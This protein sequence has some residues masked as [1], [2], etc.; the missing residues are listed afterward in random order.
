MKSAF[1]RGFTLIEMLVVVLIIG[2]LAA[3]ALPR[4]QR[5]VLESRYSKSK[6]LASAYIKAGKLYYMQRGSW[7]TLFNSLT[8]TPPKGLKRLTPYGSSDCGSSGDTYCC[9]TTGV[10]GGGGQS[11]G[12]VCGTTDYAIAL[13]YEFYGTQ[14]EIYS[15]VAKNDNETALE[16]CGEEGSFFSNSN[17]V[18]P[19]GHK[20]GY[21]FYRVSGS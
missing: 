20:T 14:P 8:I 10:V 12:V 1:K 15:C 5:A 3:I 17:L 18:T 7:P 21:S 13:R 6:T 19:E 11:P 9:L 4:Y 16:I 2:I